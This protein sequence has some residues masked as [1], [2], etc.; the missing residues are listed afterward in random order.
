MSRNSRVG[1]SLRF[2]W[3]PTVL[4]TAA[5]GLA[6]VDTSALAQP[7]PQESPKQELKGP[8]LGQT[9]PGSCARHLPR[10]R[11]RCARV[12]TRARGGS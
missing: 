10:P 11:R 6:T 1:K 7:V 9:P 2:V 8:Y 3:F 4:W 5:L 12:V